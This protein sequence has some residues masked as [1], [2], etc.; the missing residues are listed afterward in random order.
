MTRRRTARELYREA[1]RVVR[2][3]EKPYFIYRPFTMSHYWKAVTNM[4]MRQRDD[5]SCWLSKQR[6]SQWRVGMI[7][8]YPQLEQIPF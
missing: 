7:S 4:D 3:Q 8:R 1:W 5:V 6:Q 2:M